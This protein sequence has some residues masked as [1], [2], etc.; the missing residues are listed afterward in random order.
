MMHHDRGGGLDFQSQ[1]YCC[2]LAE[3]SWL[4]KSLN[5][6]GPQFSLLLSGGSGRGIWM[7]EWV[8]PT[9]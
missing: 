6:S 1:G 5:L 9:S 4:E 2:L 7:G 3:W 8:I